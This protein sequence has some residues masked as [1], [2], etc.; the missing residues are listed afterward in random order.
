MNAAFLRLIRVNNTKFGMFGVLK[1]NEKVFCVTL[2]PSDKENHNSISCIPTGQYRCVKV[3]SPRFGKTWTVTDVTDRSKILFHAGNVVRHTL[4][5][6][7]VAEYFGKLGPNMAI[8]NSGKTFYRFLRV[9]K[10]YDELH[11]TIQEC[12]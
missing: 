1:I 2:E 4:G 10:D 12:F 5:C 7:L 6:I 3:H 8:L 11:L 9:L